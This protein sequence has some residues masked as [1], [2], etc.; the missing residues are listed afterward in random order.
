MNTYTE[1]WLLAAGTLFGLGQMA[2]FFA[3]GG[4]R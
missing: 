1:L 4:G 2:A 3:F